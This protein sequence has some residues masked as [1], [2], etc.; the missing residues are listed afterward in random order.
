MVY[1]K[2]QISFYPSCLPGVIDLV[3]HTKKVR[4]YRKFDLFFP[5]ELPPVCLHFKIFYR[6]SSKNTL[7]KEDPLL[8]WE[9]FFLSKKDFLPP[10]FS[11]H[12]RGRVHS[13]AKALISLFS[14]FLK[15]Q[16]PVYEEE[17]SFR[18]FLFKKWTRFFS[19][20]LI[21]FEKKILFFLLRLFQHKKIPD[22]KS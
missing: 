17:F 14:L 18:R 20:P 16:K 7:F 10:F 13:S 5:Q 4:F 22:R 12:L 8:R 1:M 2:I 21:P 9:F 6:D 15:G 3:S 19:P 11:L